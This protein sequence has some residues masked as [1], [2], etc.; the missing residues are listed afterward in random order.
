MV[1]IEELNNS[2]IAEVLQRVGYGHLGMSRGVYPYVVPIHYVYKDQIIYFFTTEGKKT[3]II[4][5]N[6]EICLQVEE[7]TDSKHWKSVIVVGTARRVSEKEEI[8]RAMEAILAVN[9]TLTPALSVRWMDFWV[10]ENVEVIYRVIPRMITGR[11]TLAHE[12]DALHLSDKRNRHA[13]Y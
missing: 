7:V 9:P 6:P 2:Q 1:E 3:E 8:D 12:T 5:S 11:A 10:R 13:V 4:R